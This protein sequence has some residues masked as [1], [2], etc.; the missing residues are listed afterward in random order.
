MDF[1]LMMV[2]LPLSYLYKHL[3]EHF[4]LHHLLHQSRHQQSSTDWHDNGVVV[5]HCNRVENNLYQGWS[6]HVLNKEH[7]TLQLVG[8]ILDQKSNV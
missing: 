3:H 7:N 8:V 2:N 4:L 6:H 5:L 1:D